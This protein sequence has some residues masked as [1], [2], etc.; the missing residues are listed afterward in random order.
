MPLPPPRRPVG[1]GRAPLSLS[2]VSGWLPC[3][4]RALPR[5][6]SKVSRRRPQAAL[7]FLP[8]GQA[9]PA[10]QSSSPQ[11]PL[12]SCLHFSCLQGSGL[13]P[14]APRSQHGRPGPQCSGAAVGSSGPETWGYLC[15]HGA[16]L[17]SWVAA[18]HPGPVPSWD[19]PAPG[20]RCTCPACPRATSLHTVRSTRASK[21]LRTERCP[22]PR[23][24]YRVG[25]K[26]CAPR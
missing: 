4:P 1:C 24:R 10:P 5:F 14:P 16:F 8:L 9:Q 12:A 20:F 6:S 19:L 26:F 23:V 25:P 11:L 13:P 17:G 22:A 3:R 18:A 21:R 2:T 15:P 7:P